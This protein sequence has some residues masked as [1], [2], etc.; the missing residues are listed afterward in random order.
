MKIK[1]RK[2]QMRKLSSLPMASEREKSITMVVS[3]F[4]YI[5]NEITVLSGSITIASSGRNWNE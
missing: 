5:F 2:K 4:T 1:T 3:Y